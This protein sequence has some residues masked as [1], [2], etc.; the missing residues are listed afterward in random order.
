MSQILAGIFGPLYDCL[1]L[2]YIDDNVVNSKIPFLISVTSIVK[3]LGNPLAQ[4]IAS[5][6]LKRYIMP[7]ATPTITQ[8]DPRWLGAWWLGW[9]IIGLS[10]LTFSFL[11]SLFPRELPRAALRRKIGNVKKKLFDMHHSKNEEHD[12]MTNEKH[13]LN[14]QSFLL[15]LKSIATNKIFMINTIS[16]VF[17]L[18]GQHPYWMYMQKYIET[19]YQQSTSES[20]LVSNHICSC[21][22]IIIFILSV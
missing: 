17:Y 16:Y 4:F 18:L 11:V 21:I 19:Q 2:P 3:M 5:F 7:S 12:N 6:S 20:K 9:L 13:L 22:F 8:K 14:I 15:A 10:L 1:G